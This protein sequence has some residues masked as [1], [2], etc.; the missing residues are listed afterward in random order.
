[1]YGHKRF[2]VNC[3][4]NRVGIYFLKYTCIC[5]IAGKLFFDVYCIVNRVGDIFK[6]IYVL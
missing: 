5:I 3:I 4:V 6:N 1:M 2:A